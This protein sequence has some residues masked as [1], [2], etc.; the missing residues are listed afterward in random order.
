MSS[1]IFPIHCFLRSGVSSTSVNFCIFI[2]FSANLIKSNNLPN[3]SVDQLVPSHH[4]SKS[5]RT[6]NKL[7]ITSWV[8]PSD[9]TPLGRGGPTTIPRARGE[10]PSCGGPPDHHLSASIRLVWSSSAHPHPAS[11]ERE[12]KASGLSGHLAPRIAFLLWSLL[13]FSLSLVKGKT[14]CCSRVACWPLFSFLPTVVGLTPGLPNSAKL[15]QLTQSSVRV[16]K[17]LGVESGGCNT[18]RSNE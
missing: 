12:K 4:R 10:L 13:S 15:L 16:S 7:V 9:S 17:L 1:R 3:F 6:V 2:I 14:N 18:S 11:G 5:D 8:I